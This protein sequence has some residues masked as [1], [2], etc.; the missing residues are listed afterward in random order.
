MHTEPISVSVP[1][2]IIAPIGSLRKDSVFILLMQSATNKEAMHTLLYYKSCDQLP[3][4]APME[5]LQRTYCCINNSIYSALFLC[6]WSH[7]SC[8]GLSLYTQLM[9]DNEFELSGKA[10]HR[11]MLYIMWESWEW[12]LCTLW[13]L[14]LSWFVAHTGQQLVILSHY[15]CQS[16][17]KSLSIF[18]GL[19]WA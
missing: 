7:P 18:W 9:E 4:W 17:L 3:Y 13:I 8:Y 11:K 19:F 14:M 6:Y 15:T 16:D 1:G 2:A 5:V 12:C 10:E